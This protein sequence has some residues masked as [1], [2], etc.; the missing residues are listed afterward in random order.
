METKSSIKSIE[1]DLLINDSQIRALLDTG[2]QLSYIS[3]D[4][5]MQNNLSL[6]KCPNF[7]IV[8]ANGSKDCGDE[9]AKLKC[10]VLNENIEFCHDYRVLP[11]MTKEIIL[12]MDFIID[13]DVQINLKDKK[14]IIRGNEIS[15]IKH[16]I[17]EHV[18]IEKSKL[19]ALE[20][21]SRYQIPIEVQEY[22]KEYKENNPEIGSIPTVKHQIILKDKI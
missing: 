15:L 16:S 18:L 12:G 13:N 5:C 8:C 3:K 22:I 1:L 10:R 21:E 6:E 11:R 19:C 20:I 14:V 4:S 17:P 7:Q 9:I 2:S